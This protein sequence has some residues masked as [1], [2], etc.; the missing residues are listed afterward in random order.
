MVGLGI[1][2]LIVGAI[3]EA[4]FAVIVNQVISWEIMSGA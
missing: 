1:S 3:L 4:W 2:V